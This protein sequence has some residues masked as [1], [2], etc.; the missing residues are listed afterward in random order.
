MSIEIKHCT[1]SEIESS[2]NID[3]IV[4]EYGNET[5]VD[6][7]PAPDTKFDIYRNLEASGKLHIIGAFVDD[8]LVGF[9]S[10]LDT[11]SPHYNS[12]V[13]ISE[14]FFVLKEH[15]KGGAGIKL[16][17]AAE[18]H[19]LDVGS[20][21]LIITART[22]GALVKL[23][24][25]RGYK[26][27]HEIHFRSSK[28]QVATKP[29]AVANLAVTNNDNNSL[30]P[31]SEAAINKVR[32]IEAMCMTLPQIFIETTHDF[33]AGMYARTI[34]IPAGCLLTGTLMKVETI[35]VLNGAGNLFTGNDVVPISGHYVFKGGAG[36]KQV[37]YATTDTY[38]TMLFPTESTTVEEAEEEFTDEADKLLSRWQT[39]ENYLLKGDAA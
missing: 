16:L 12:Q 3:Y 5:A 1:V 26:Q 37:F 38:A 23:L 33:H 36:R 32:E 29:L 15:R 6:G 9:I 19:A 11:I 35:L 20:E 34:K 27:T 10:T 7:M 13:S 25:L 8:V 17:E 14:S 30:L 24:P 2:P 21:G 39:P 28:E 31:M 18:K 4:A 22:G